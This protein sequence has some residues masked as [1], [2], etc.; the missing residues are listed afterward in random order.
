MHILEME[1]AD[2][3]KAHY[4]QADGSYVKPDK[5]GRKLM[6]SQEEFC[7]EA[8]QEA[9]KGSLNRMKFGYGTGSSRRF[10]PK[11]PTAE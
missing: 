6:S 9:K 2:T 8:K 7:K 10:I 5:R 1:I 11:T 3:K 4:M